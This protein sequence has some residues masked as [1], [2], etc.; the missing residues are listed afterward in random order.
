MK[1]VPSL[2]LI[3]VIRQKNEE[4]TVHFGNSVIMVNNGP[5]SAIMIRQEQTE[6]KLCFGS[7]MRGYA[8]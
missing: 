6:P 7:P 3:A 5:P 2:L 4:L 1:R 8:Q